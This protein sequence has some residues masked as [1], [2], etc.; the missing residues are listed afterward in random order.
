MTWNIFN[1]KVFSKNVS[2]LVQLITPTEYKIMW[3]AQRWH[4]KHKHVA[5]SKQCIRGDWFLLQKCIPYIVVRYNLISTILWNEVCYKI[6]LLKW[7]NL[8]CPHP[9]ASCHILMRLY[10]LVCFLTNTIDQAMC[11][12]LNCKGMVLL[13]L[14]VFVVFYGIKF[15]PNSINNR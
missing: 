8:T 11:I 13:Q 1:N 4:F 2:I 6:S 7:H 12:P 3:N 5:V 15:L 14:L 10:I 9:N